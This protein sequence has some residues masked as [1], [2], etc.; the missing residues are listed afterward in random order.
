M[1]Q[2][3]HRVTPPKAMPTAKPES[4]KPCRW[5]G[6]SVE[7]FEVVRAAAAKEQMRVWLCEIAIEEADRTVDTGPFGVKD[8]PPVREMLD[9]SEKED[10]DD[11]EDGLE[12]ERETV[13]G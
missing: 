2:A 4:D 3:K 9:R 8:R 1:N 5:V 13:R 10:S 11:R 6:F 7:E 12:P